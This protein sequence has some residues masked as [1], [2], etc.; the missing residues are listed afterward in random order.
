[1]PLVD[2]LGTL[3]HGGANLYGAMI[4]A[5]VAVRMVEFAVDQVVD[6]IAVRHRFMAAA[7]TVFMLRIMP[8][9][10]AEVMTLVGI[11]LANGKNVFLQ[12]VAFLVTEMT[13]DQEIDV[14]IVLNRRVTATGT[15]RM[16]ALWHDNLRNRTG[17]WC[18]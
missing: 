5:M 6:V 13:I 7:G 3:R 12:L 2:Y 10:V 15:V 4:V 18:L 16:G 11:R 1:M 14:A 9:L 8:R 17:K